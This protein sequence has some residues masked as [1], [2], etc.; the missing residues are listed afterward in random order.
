MKKLLSV[1]L[2]IVVLFSSF[3]FV[4]S[5]DV[6]DKE[7]DENES[8]DSFATANI[9]YK[10]Y[11][12]FGYLS[13][14]YDMD[15][16]KFTLTSKSTITFLCSSKVKG[17]LVGLYDSSQEILTAGSSYYDDGYY[18]DKINQTLSPGTYYLLFLQESGYSNSAYLYYFD[19]ESISHTHS[20]T[21]KVTKPA[22]CTTSGIKTYTCSCGDSYTE[23]VAK[24]EANYD[25]LTYIMYLLEMPNRPS[26]KQA[27]EKRSKDELNYLSAKEADAKSVSEE[28]KSALEHLRQELKRLSKVGD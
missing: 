12:V 10:D 17:I 16:F 8:N 26:K 22:L 18:Y 4:A 11:T 14:Q 3:T 6:G 25:R 9:I 23:D 13:S 21:S 20:Y 24:L 28:N 5:A 19:Y 7:F 15:Y 27:H 1:I 2:S